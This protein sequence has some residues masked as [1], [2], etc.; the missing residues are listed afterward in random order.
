MTRGRTDAPSAAPS[1]A[2]GAAEPAGTDPT[3]RPHADVLADGAGGLTFDVR[4]PE[5]PP[6]E[7]RAV[8]RPALLLRRRRRG[9]DGGGE[10]NGEAERTDA[11][12]LPLTPAEPEGAWRAALPSTMP[13]AEGRWD[14]HLDPGEG[15]PVR[16]V[17]GVHDLRALVDREPRTDR[18]WL[19]VRIPYPT[20]HGNLTVRSWRRRPHAEAGALTVGDD[21]VELCGRLYGAAL[22]AGAQLEARPR[23]S[24]ASAVVVAARPGTGSGAG[25]FRAALPYAPL[26]G[27]PVWDLWLR[28]ADGAEAVRLAR[29]LDDV[30][31]KKHI[32][33]YP[34][35]ELPDSAGGPGAAVRPYYTRNNGL[36]VRVTRSGDAETGSETG[37]AAPV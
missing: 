22:T 36:S 35:R 7:P 4:L 31:D 13:L 34:V 32:F 29:I 14:V 18:A 33:S 30:P 24:S 5:P 6:G 19:A 27:R 23:R 26:L 21:E 1:A 3:A 10:G 37:R 11:V 20:R 8:P 2:L 12:R 28:P 15:G 9:G 17:A 25:H 16:M